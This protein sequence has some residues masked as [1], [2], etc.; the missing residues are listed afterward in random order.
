M[1]L[2][3]SVFQPSFFPTGSD[4]VPAFEHTTSYISLGDESDG[5]ETH[6]LSFMLHSFQRAEWRDTIVKNKLKVSEA[7]TVTIDL[8]LHGNDAPLSRENSDAR[9]AKRVK[10]VDRELFA[11][12]AIESAEGGKFAVHR[13]MLASSSDVLTA[14]LDSCGVMEEGKTGLLK[15]PDFSSLSIQVRFHL[16]TP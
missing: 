13:M 2:L 16:R 14:M 5:A 9:L 12:F 8:H 15:L 7:L 4:R 11:D 6:D 1:W 3:T 10:L